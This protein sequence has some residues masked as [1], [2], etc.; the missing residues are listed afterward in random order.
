MGFTVWIKSA[1]R[2]T[3]WLH[4]FLTAV[5]HYETFLRGLAA[6]NSLI[7]LSA[8]LPTIQDGAQTGVVGN[9]RKDVT[10]SQ[11]D[12]TALTILFNKRI[13]RFCRR[14]HIEYVS[15]DE[16]SLDPAKG[17]VKSSLRHS[18][19]TNHHYCPIAYSAL[20]TAALRSTL[21]R[22]WTKAQSA[23]N[24]KPSSPAP[25]SNVLSRLIF[26]Q[27]ADNSLLISPLDGRQHFYM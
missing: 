9:L 2:G 23:L 10:A 11:R 17:V 27:R 18:D 25:P 26:N 19:V 8:P 14:N 21:N 3:T 22:E 1:S 24:E 12:R 15:L 13:G 5:K 20:L 6:R 4:S 16:M 7:V